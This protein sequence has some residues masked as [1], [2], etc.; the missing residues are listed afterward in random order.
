MLGM[1]L[2]ADLSK[3]RGFRQDIKYLKNSGSFREMF[4]VNI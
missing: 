4:E 3:G 1:R 2:G